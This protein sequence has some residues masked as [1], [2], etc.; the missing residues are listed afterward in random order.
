MKTDYRVA[1]EFWRN[2]NLVPVGEV[3]SLTAKQAQYL[4]HVLEA[5]VPV[6]APVEAPAAPAPVAEPE[7]EN[8]PARKPKPKAPEAVAD[9]DE[10]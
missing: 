5:A 2:G 6:E 9:G 1:R 4:G 10:H 7:P 3:L 8:K